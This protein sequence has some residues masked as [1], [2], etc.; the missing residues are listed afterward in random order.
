MSQPEPIFEE[1]IY[2]AVLMNCSLAFFHFG[3]EQEGAGR[4]VNNHPV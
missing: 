4:A 3:T 1:E 2:G